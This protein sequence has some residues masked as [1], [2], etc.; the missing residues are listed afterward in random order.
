LRRARKTAFVQTET[1]KIMENLEILQK[2]RAAKN[3]GG[4]AMGTGL[5]EGD[6]INE[7][8]FRD[9]EAESDAR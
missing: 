5:I 3:K 7:E 6:L 1:L 8:K 9:E 4:K 2:R